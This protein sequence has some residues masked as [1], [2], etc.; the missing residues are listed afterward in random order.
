[1]Y[2]V[3]SIPATDETMDIAQACYKKKKELKGKNTS[4]TYYRVTLSNKP[5]QNTRGY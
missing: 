5:R 4:M 3:Q 2:V 1:M